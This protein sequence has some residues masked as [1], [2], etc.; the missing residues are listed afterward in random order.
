MS[1]AIQIDGTGNRYQM[2]KLLGQNMPRLKK[3]TDTWAP[4]VL[5][6]ENQLADEE[7]VA[8]C[9][10]KKLSGYRTQDIQKKRF[11]QDDFVD[12]AWVRQLIKEKGLHCFY[13][14]EPVFLVY[15]K[16]RE[17]KQWT[18]DRIDNEIGH[19][20]GNVVTACLECNLARRRRSKDAFLFT[21][22][23]VIRREGFFS[24]DSSSSCLQE[25][26]S[27]R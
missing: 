15:E 23:L 21:K 14:A 19:V 4:E 7:R 18:L 5:L 27:P 25:S 2:K 20:R 10:Q 16:A 22:N 17:M 26:D 12:V 6:H 8:A 9:L 13:C 11:S 24:Q 3:G 1:K